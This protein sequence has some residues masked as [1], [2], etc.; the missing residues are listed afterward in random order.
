M[1]KLWALGCGLLFMATPISAA[2]L[3]VGVKAGT[4][5]YGVE[6]SVAV[7]KNTAIRVMG[8]RLDTD[9]E[10][11]TISV[12]DSGFEGDVDSELDFDFGAA[13]LFFDWHVFG[14]G[15]HLTVGAFQNNGEA[16]LNALLVDDVVING[17][18]LATDDLGPLSGEL[19]L[20]DSLQPYVGIGWGRKTGNAGL[21]FSL[22]IGV[23]LLDPEVS[24][25]A[26]VNGGG[27]NGYTQAQLDAILNDLE[28][29]ADDDLD[30]YEYWPVVALG[31]N[32]GF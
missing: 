1:K 20:G 29:D 21:S 4:N 13:A 12:G 9:D 22:D 2:D 6:L 25:D 24:V 8:A 32:Y 19:S 16:D 5:G 23:A 7:T 30:D 11:E 31:I 3:G 15:F 26:T 17:V 18:P 28:S 27:T 14:G 10:D